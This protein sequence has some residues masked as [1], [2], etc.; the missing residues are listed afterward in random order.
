MPDPVL[1]R[2][3]DE[4]KDLLPSAVLLR[5]R[6]HENPELGLDLPLTTQAV[7]DELQGLDIDIARRTS[8]SGLIVSLT[9]TKPGSQSGRTILLRGDM[10]ALPMPEETGLEFAS[11]I[12][13][14][15][16]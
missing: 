7:L 12:P 9:G 16:P 8:T 4:A 2:F 14:L 11:K 6:I 3:L 5:R 1:S 10:D 13:G 15:R